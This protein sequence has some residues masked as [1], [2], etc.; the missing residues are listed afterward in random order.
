ME[1]KATS[2]NWPRFPDTFRT[3]QV[4]LIARWLAGGESGMII[5][6]S[7]AGKSNLVGFL[8]NRPD[9]MATRI[10]RQPERYC[11]LLLDINALPALTVPVFYRGLFQSLS[12]A[13]EQVDPELFRTVQA[14]QAQS[15]N[16]DDT[17]AV[18]TLLQKAHRLFIRQAEKKVVWLLD[19]FDEACRYLDAQTLNSLRGL[20]DQFKGDLTYLLFTRQPLARLRS[21]S[22]IDEFYEIVAANTCWL[23]P[24]VEADSRWMAQYLAAR[25]NVTF[26]E[27]VVTQLITMTGGLPAFLKGACLALAQ[28]ELDQ[29][30]SSQGWVRQLLNRP[31]FQRNCQEIWRDLTPE[32]QHTLL[33]L[34]TG[35]DASTLD[36]NT[37][38]YLQNMGLLDEKKSI[39]SPIFA[40]YIAQQ[41]GET[42]GLLELH[43]KT[44]AVLRGG[45]ALNVELTPSEDRLLSFLL[46]HPGEI[47]Q[48]DTLIYAVWP[49]DYQA[50]GISDERLAQLVKRLRDKIEPTPTDPL[51]IQ[52]VRG[53]GYRLVQPG[54]A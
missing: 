42:A 30:Q 26:A 4:A 6:S 33:V 34:Q 18:L 5:G 41:R 29:A 31:E 40:A 50:A 52:T 54:E 13:A 23:G 11:F 24:M 21:L 47:C 8:M 16:W 44:R 15:L 27:P 49:N 25:C 43:P 14:L 35:G 9:V 10:A 1:N 53:R 3:E 20:R 32:E 39:F 46:E 37:L 36:G 45:I 48:K 22:E 19:R 2:D 12:D 51:Y 7:G 28:G 38:V 17:F